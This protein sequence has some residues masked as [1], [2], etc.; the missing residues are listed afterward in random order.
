MSLVHA[1]TVPSL[2]RRRLTAQEASLA[3]MFDQAPLAIGRLALCL[4]SQRRI[5]ASH[6]LLH[7]RR[8]VAACLR[9]TV[10]DDS[11]AG[12]EVRR[13]AMS[14]A[15]PLKEV[16]DA[17]A[18]DRLDQIAIATATRQLAF[19]RFQLGRLET[20]VASDATAAFRASTAAEAG[21]SSGRS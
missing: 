9:L 17:L 4:E 14:M 16:D 7:L 10:A 8:L 3:L 11:T 20:L 5:G 18:A 12:T 15:Q 21:R 13:T 19:I 6:A 1:G 2:N